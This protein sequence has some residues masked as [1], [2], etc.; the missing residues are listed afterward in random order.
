[1]NGKTENN[2]I[3]IINYKTDSDVDT[4]IELQIDKRKKK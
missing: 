3:Y 2:F 4:L 1:M